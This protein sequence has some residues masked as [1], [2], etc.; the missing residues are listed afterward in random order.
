VGDEETRSACAMVYL[1]VVISSV[2]GALNATLFCAGNI[3][4]ECV[5][6]LRFRFGLGIGPLHKMDWALYPSV[7]GTWP[8]RESTVEAEE[9]EVSSGVSITAELSSS[10]GVTWFE[11]TEGTLVA[12]GVKDGL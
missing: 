12:S 2:R 3:D 5:K 11:E 8:G 1:V 7:Y 9:D 10:A 6:Q 4:R